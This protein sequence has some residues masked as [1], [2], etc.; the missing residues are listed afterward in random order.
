MIAFFVFLAIGCIL[1][2]KESCKGK[3]NNNAHFLQIFMIHYDLS[4]TNGIKVL[5]LCTASFNISKLTLYTSSQ[6]SPC[7]FPNPCPY[8]FQSFRFLL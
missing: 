6:C 3:W 1:K 7:G 4:S 2:G 5:N 8:K